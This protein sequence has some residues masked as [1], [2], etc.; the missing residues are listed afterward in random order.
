[1]FYRV[2]NVLKTARNNVSQK[3]PP[4]VFCK[5]S[6]FGNFANFTG[7]H[8]CQSFFLNNSDTGVFL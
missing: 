5:K 6:V 7:K 3:Q 2:L 1:M 4:E 8:L